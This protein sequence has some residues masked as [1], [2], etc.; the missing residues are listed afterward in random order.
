MI[1]LN[2]E[3]FDEAVSQGTVLVDFWATWCMPCKASAPHFEAFAAENPGIKAVKVNIDDA[4]T[5]AEKMNIQAVPTFI[6]LKDGIEVK[7]HCG[8]ASKAILGS[9]FSAQ[10]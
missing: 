2:D 1:E 7:R 10:T 3:N 5:A 4:A 8:S 9:K 6:L